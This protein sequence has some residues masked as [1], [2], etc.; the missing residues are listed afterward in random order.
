MKSTINPLLINTLIYVILDIR[1]GTAKLT[2]RI[3]YSNIVPGNYLVILI[4]AAAALEPGR[5]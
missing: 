5:A 2:E 1:Q 3:A 4:Y